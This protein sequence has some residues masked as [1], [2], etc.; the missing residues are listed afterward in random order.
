[1]ANFYEDANILKLRSIINEL[2]DYFY[3]VISTDTTSLS[4]QIYLIQGVLEIVLNYQKMAANLTYDIKYQDIKIIFKRKLL[5]QILNEYR[6]ELLALSQEIE[7]LVANIFTFLNR[8]KRNWE[9]SIILTPDDIP[10][11]E[12]AH[13]V[14]EYYQN[15]GDLPSDIPKQVQKMLL[16][17]WQ[18]DLSSSE[19]EFSI[20]FQEFADKIQNGLEERGL[21]LHLNVLN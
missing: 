2:S 11:L 12:E 19:S 8:N 18:K 9:S 15:T 17:M 3:A 16:K 21:K 14:L 10:I 7:I 13:L 6:G 4:E 20:L 1:M 5:K